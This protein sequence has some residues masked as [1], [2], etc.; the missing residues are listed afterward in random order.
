MQVICS[1]VFFFFFIP[2][3]RLFREI[4]A[5]TCDCTIVNRWCCRGPSV[6]EAHFP[7]GTVFMQ[8]LCD[9][10]L[11]VH[12]LEQLDPLLYAS[13]TP[14]ECKRASFVGF[15]WPSQS[16]Y[17]RKLPFRLWRSNFPRTSNETKS[18]LVGSTWSHLTKLS[19]N[20]ANIQ[21]GKRAKS[22][23]LIL[24]TRT[25]NENLNWKGRFQFTEIQNIHNVI[26]DRVCW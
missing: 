22:P 11:V 3:Q 5:H 18:V 16:L 15:E 19:S 25:Q 26:D 13:R 9:L 14:E 8:T 10:L 17:A 24:A 4:A 6:S 23:N 20:C 2:C 12:K 21:R 7:N 1:R